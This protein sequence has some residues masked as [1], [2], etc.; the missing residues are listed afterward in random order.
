LLQTAQAAW[1][2]PLPCPQRVSF[3]AQVVAQFS[4]DC[5]RDISAGLQS[6]LIVGKGILGVLLDRGEACAVPPILRLQF[7][8]GRRRHLY[9]NLYT[10]RLLRLFGLRGCLQDQPVKAQLLS[11]LPFLIRFHFLKGTV[12]VVLVARPLLLVKSFRLS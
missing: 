9:R 5:F 1:L 2:P 4:L 7:L 8:V 6:R 12:V 10:E 3:V 11:S